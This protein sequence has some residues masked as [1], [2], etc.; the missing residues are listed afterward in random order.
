VVSM[1]SPKQN[2][3]ISIQTL[4]GKLL[5][6]LPAVLSPKVRKPESAMV[7]QARREMVVEM[8]VRREKRERVGVWRE[9]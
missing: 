5:R 6:M 8:W 7:R 3:A 1:L 2:R 9:V 4:E